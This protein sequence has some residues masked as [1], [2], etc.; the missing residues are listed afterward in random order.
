MG[1]DGY[2]RFVLALIF[3]IALIGVFAVIFR[4]LGFGFPVNAIRPSG[5]RRIGVVEVAPLDSRRK[6]VLVRRDDVEHLLVISPTTELVVESNIRDG[7]DFRQV[8]DETA[9]RDE[10]SGTGAEDQ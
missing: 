5:E 6:L 2:L 1:M 7:V 9:A 3:V 8:L 10:T 4:R